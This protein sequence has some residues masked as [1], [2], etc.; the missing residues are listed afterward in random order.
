MPCVLVLLRQQLRP[1]LFLWHPNC[2]LHLVLG[3]R[4]FF[5]S[6]GPFGQLARLLACAQEYLRLL[7]CR[8]DG[9]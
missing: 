1:S 8:R 9:G 3:R 7:H 5:P 6:I 4:R 2:L